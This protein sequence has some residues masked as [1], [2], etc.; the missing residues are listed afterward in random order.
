MKNWMRPALVGIVVVVVG[1]SAAASAA[2]SQVAI[3]ADVVYGHKEGT[4]L[5]YDVFTPAD[6]NGAGIVF[7]VSGGWYSVWQPPAARIESFDAHLNAGFTVFA[8]HHAS[9]PRF[10]VPEAVSDVRG[11]I[12]HIKLHASE[13]GVDPDRLGVA[14]GSA[15]GHLALMLG[16]SPEVVPD[17]PSGQGNRSLGPFY[18]APADTD[19]TVAVV[20]AYF[21]PTDLR[22]MVGPNDRFPAL[23]FPSDGAAAISPILFVTPDDPP[24]KL[25]HG[26]ADELVA[27]E[28]SERLV[29]E[30]ARLGVPHD[31]LVIEGGDHGFRDPGHA[32]EA[33]AAS[34]AWFRRY[35]E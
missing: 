25:I 34:L 18:E 19:A 13:F 22:S 16:L 17:P 30:M 10:K 24:V 23:D 1:A 28:H 32:A 15:G 11:A 35:L 5:F 4:A 7:M 14:G 33:M 12:R 9:A 27:L 8:V 2:D 3:R 31:L 21:P 20:V 6:A 29:A 26:D